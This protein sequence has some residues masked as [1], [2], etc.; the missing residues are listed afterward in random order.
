MP[1]K[2]LC[3]DGGNGRWDVENLRSLRQSNRI[4]FKHLAVNRL[5]AESHLR[6]M[7][8]EDDLTILGGQQFQL[9][10]HYVLSVRR[11]VSGVTV[12]DEVF[13][14]F[15]NHIFYNPTIWFCTILLF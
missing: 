7:I 3:F 8:N 12:S 5:N 6:L 15:P 13:T 11:L 14:Y 2:A 4:I 1:R 9:F 10:G